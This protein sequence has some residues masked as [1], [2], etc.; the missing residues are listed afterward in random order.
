MLRR[1]KEAAEWCARNITDVKYSRNNTVGAAAR[2]ASVS[3]ART[4][5]RFAWAKAPF[6]LST[7]LSVLQARA[8]DGFSG[9]AAARRSPSAAAR[10]VRSGRLAYCQV[11]KRSQ[12]R[13][14]SAGG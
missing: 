11:T 12:P 1:W 4:A 10:A 5:A 7:E 13:S 9:T 14:S 3:Y 8:C 6:D 2:K